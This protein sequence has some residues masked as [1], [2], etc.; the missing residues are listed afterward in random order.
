MSGTQTVPASQGTPTPPEPQ[1]GSEGAPEDAAANHG[2]APRQPKPRKVRRV[3]AQDVLVRAD[4]LH[5]RLE[6]ICL[7]GELTRGECRL[8]E[9]AVERLDAAK[10]AALKVHPRPRRIS[11]WWRG[12]LVDAAYQNLHAGGDPH[13]EHLRQHPG[14]GGGA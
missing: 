6:A 12:T 1:R 3:W 10:D 9:R 4:L 14:K 8:A 2:R 11:N 5:A 7:D 13:G